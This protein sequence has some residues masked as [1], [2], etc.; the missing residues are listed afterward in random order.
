LNNILDDETQLKAIDKSSMF[1]IL[2]KFPELCE[3]ALALSSSLKFPREVAINGGEMIRY[4]VPSQVIVVGMGG[5]AIGGDLIK[6]WLEDSLP[7]PIEVYR[8]Y[9][10]PAYASPNTLV[11]AVSY[12]G[13]T[14]ETLS[15]Y[16]DAAERKCMTLSV[17]SGGLLEEFN[18][19]LGLPY[20]KL[21]RGY[22]PR[23]AMPYLFFPL[24]IGLHKLGV[25]G[26]Y[27]PDVDDALK[28][29]KEIREE[30]STRTP[31]YKNPSKKLALELQGSLPM[32]CGFGPFDAVATRLKTQFN[33]NGKTPAKAEFFSELNHN[34]TLGWSGLRKLT[35]LFSVILIR[36]DDEPPEIKARIEVTRRLVLDEGAQRVVEINTRGR[37]RLARMLS[38]MYIGDFASVYLGILY[39]ID[40]TPTPIIDELKRQLETRLNKPAEL[41]ARIARLRCI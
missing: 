23:S 4:H 28:A 11:I 2:E 41:K 29:V 37:G 15:A 33:E 38:A 39:G 14:E 27:Q 8:E 13:N 35:K 3:D 21:P 26:T 10:L 34:E 19:E 40:P 6:D 20:V 9:H 18:L 16:V 22:P 17:S 30:I 24:I 1:G 12:S 25:L 7:I 36:S 31:T 5:S 32:V